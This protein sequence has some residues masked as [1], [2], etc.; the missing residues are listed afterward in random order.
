MPKS[1]RERILDVALDLFTE[2]GYDQTS[3]REI[4]EQLGL[5]KAALYYHFASK[6]AIFLALHLRL[7][8]IAAGSSAILAQGPVTIETWG[9]LLDSFIDQIPP[10][11]KLVL[12]H[13]RN[14]VA[15]EKLHHADHAQEHEDLESV[16]HLALSNPAVPLRD[17]VR[18]GCAFATMMG[19]ILLGGDAFGEVSS[20]QLVVELKSAIHDLLDRH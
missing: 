13:E 1:T 7:H 8:A 5:T 20:D 18:M 17:R 3:L 4:A 6:E 14:R 12:M 9:A 19:G 11:R 2:Q 15:F 16:L 10:N